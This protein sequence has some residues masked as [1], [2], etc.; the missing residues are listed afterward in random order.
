MEATEFTSEALQEIRVRP[1]E[2]G[3][4][5][6]YQEQMARHHYLGALAKIGETAWY[7]ATW[8][9]QWVAQ[10]NLSAAAL[11]CGVRDRWIGWDLRSQ[12]GRLNLIANSTASSSCPEF[13]KSLT[14]C[15]GLYFHCFLLL[16]KRPSKSTHYSFDRFELREGAALKHAA[17]CQQGDANRWKVPS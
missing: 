5:A 17:K 16:E 14:R 4:E 3:E 9:E 7:V 6:R 2:P 13:C 12:Y 1:V 10:L 11:Q 8:R 15:W